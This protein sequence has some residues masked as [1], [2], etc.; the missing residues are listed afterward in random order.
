MNA[1]PYTLFKPYGGVFDPPDLHRIEGYFHAGLSFNMAPATVI[2]IF[3]NA[4]R[5]NA[6]MNLFA[7]PGGNITWNPATATLQAPRIQAQ[8]FAGLRGTSS[9]IGGSPLAL[10]SCT[11]GVASIP[12]ATLN[13]V[14]VTVA[15]TIGAP[16]FSAQGAFQVTA[17]VTA[18]DQVTVSICALIA[19]TP[20]SSS[21]IVALQ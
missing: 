14:P 3:G 10:G 1:N 12:G 2:Q 13:M 9:P 11:T 7:M 19:G 8:N 21:Y 5:S 18:P 20:R 4:D 16:G 15:S 17:Q 6:I